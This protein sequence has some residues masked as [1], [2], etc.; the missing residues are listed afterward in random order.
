[1]KRAIVLMTGL[2]L[3]TACGMPDI[4]TEMAAFNGAVDAAAKPLFAQLDD[5]KTAAVARARAGAIQRGETVWGAPTPCLELVVGRVEATLAACTLQRRFDVPLERGTPHYSAEA[6]ETL[7]AYAAVLTELA[8]STAPAEI[9]ASFATFLT[10]INGVAA[11]ARRSEAVDVAP[12][13]VERIKPLSGIAGRLAEAAR[14]RAIRRLVNQA[15]KPLEGVIREL[16]AQQRDNDG[17][18]TEYEGLEN[19]YVAMEKLK[20]TPGSAAYAEAVETYETEMA[21]FRARARSSHTARL[22][23]VLKAQRLLRLRVN[24]AGDLEDL[25]ALLEDLKALS[26]PAT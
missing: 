25:V 24:Q 8:T 21:A 26:D 2:A 10:A 13:P 17:L 6:L 3:P 14:Y 19:A 5:E 15:D 7:R 9:G 23:L 16:I 1:M 4:S 18:R 20:G 22:I 11:A 12:I